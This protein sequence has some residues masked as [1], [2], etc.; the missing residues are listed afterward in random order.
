MVSDQ[1]RLQTHLGEVSLTRPALQ[2]RLGNAL[3]FIGYRAE[4]PLRE[5]ERH[6]RSLMELLEALPDG[7]V[8]AVDPPAS[9]DWTGSVRFV[10]ISR[11]TFAGPAFQ[12]EAATFLG[13][14]I[15]D[16]LD[17]K[18]SKDPFRRV[19]V[20]DANTKSVLLESALRSTQVR[21]PQRHCERHSR[22]LRHECHWRGPRRRESAPQLRR[23]CAEHGR[24]DQFAVLRS[25]VCDLGRG[26]GFLWRRVPLASGVPAGSVEP[27][28]V[29]GWRRWGPR[30]RAGALPY[31]CLCAEHRR[32]DRRQ[33]PVTLDLANS[34]HVD[35]VE[36]GIHSHSTHI[37]SG[38]FAGESPSTR[39]TR[40]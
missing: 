40:S 10:R 26:A 18:V 19:W 11:G 13:N 31:R 16:R 35:P 25:G 27:A 14:P 1:S 5:R 28:L 8:G 29:G 37:M 4:V 22:A 34:D 39:E 3:V 21:W 33:A 6:A 2:A 24:R 17:Q 32:G 12:V 9:L 20:Y 7:F 38:T 23:L 30:R 36:I 15:V